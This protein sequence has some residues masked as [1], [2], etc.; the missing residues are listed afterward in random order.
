MLQLIDQKWREHLA[1]MDYLRE[2]IGLRAIG[3]Q[4]P[5]VAWQKEGYEMFGHLISAIDDDFVKYAM[6]V[7]VVVE[8]PEEPDFSQ[9][10]LVAADEPVQSLSGSEAAIREAQVVGDA[11]RMEE[12]IEDE[13]TMQPVVKGE[14]E[15]L[16]RNAPCW[17]G[18]GKKYKLCHGR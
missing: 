12:M 6:H 2:G 7:D 11:E 5:L 1:E 9:A 3:Q 8:K 15:K 10:T 4:D 14:H 18:S 16:G 17:C 13:P